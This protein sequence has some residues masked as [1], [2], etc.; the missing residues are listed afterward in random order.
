MPTLM[1][2][3]VEIELDYKGIKLSTGDITK[4][5]GSSDGS[6]IEVLEDGAM[7]AKVSLNLPEGADSFTLNAEATAVPEGGN[8]EDF[9]SGSMS[10]E[11][12]YSGDYEADSDETSGVEFL[13]L[14]TLL[15]EDGSGFPG[16]G[17]VRFDSLTLDAG[18]MVEVSSDVILGPSQ[19]EIDT[20]SQRR[21]DLA[22]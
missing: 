16:L 9:R 15:A 20:A 1:Q 8:L 22:I 6:Q 2:V 14:S 18:R 12:H 4:A 13:E 7:I 17:V 11:V 5:N 19:E 10:K 21:L 3:S